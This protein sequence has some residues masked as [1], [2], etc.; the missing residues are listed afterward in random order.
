MTGRRNAIGEGDMKR[1]RWGCVLPLER[2]D[3]YVIAALELSCGRSSEN[4]WATTNMH[5]LNTCSIKYAIF[6]GVLLIL[7]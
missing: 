6:V 4:I 1:L 2:V 7:G 3:M 5:M